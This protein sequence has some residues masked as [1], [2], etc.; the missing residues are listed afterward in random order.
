M[1]FFNFFYVNVKTQIKFEKKRYLNVKTCKL[2]LKKRQDL[3]F[4]K[5]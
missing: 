2:N 5:V 3:E 4:W 1:K